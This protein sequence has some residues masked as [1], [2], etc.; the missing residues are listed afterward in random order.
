MV[1]NLVDHPELTVRGVFQLEIDK[2]EPCRISAPYAES[3]HLPPL[4]TS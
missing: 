1:E 3:T 2:L 4:Q